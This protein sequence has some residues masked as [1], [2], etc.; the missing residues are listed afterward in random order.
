[1]AHSS[2]LT[3]SYRYPLLDGTNNILLYYPKKAQY[4]VDLFMV[5]AGTG[6][7]PTELLS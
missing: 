3:D 5:M 2:I 1:M 6:I 4:V 7:Y